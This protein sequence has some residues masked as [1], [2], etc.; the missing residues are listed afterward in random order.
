M[1]LEQAAKQAMDYLDSVG[2]AADYDIYKYGG[3]GVVIITDYWSFQF[4]RHIALD[5]FMNVIKNRFPQK[6]P[7][8]SRAFNSDLKN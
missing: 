6:A 1:T 7:H 3:F 8:N 5:R 4:V 2:V